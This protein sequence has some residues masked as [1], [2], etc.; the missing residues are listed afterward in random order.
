M[1]SL[2]FFPVS[3][4]KKKEKVKFVFFFIRIRIFCREIHK[5]SHV[6]EGL[7][8]VT[9][10][11]RWG[12]GSTSLIARKTYWSIRFRYFILK[13]NWIFCFHNIWIWFLFVACKDDRDC[14]WI[15]KNIGEGE[16][17]KKYCNTWKHKK[18]I[19][20][21]RETCKLCKLRWYKFFFQIQLDVV[22]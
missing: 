4:F 10:F 9:Q 13:K 5:R 11:V 6:G 22:S 14:S 12:R 20:E 19:Q 2:P 18:A 1:T 16:P 3:Q 17:L 8:G 15:V 7:R 21:C